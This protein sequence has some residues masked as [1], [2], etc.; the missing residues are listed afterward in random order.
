[1][2][3]PIFEVQ[4]WMLGAN[5][6]ATIQNEFNRG[7]IVLTCRCVNDVWEYAVVHWFKGVAS[8]LVLVSNGTVIKQNHELE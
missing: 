2:A 7:L 4:W 6:I 8:L 3:K 5:E 1:M